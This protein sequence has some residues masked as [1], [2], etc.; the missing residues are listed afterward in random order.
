MAESVPSHLKSLNND[1]PTFVQFVN[2]SD[3]MVY[4]FWLDYT[5]KLVRYGCIPPHR[6]ME[7]NTYVTH[8]WV[9]RDTATWYPL[10]LNGEQIF[11]PQIER[12]E[13]LFHDQNRER[14]DIHIPVFPLF[15]RCLEVV[16][17]YFQKE[18]IAWTNIPKNIKEVLLKMSTPT[19]FNDYKHFDSVIYGRLHGNDGVNYDNNDDDEEDVEDDDVDSDEEDDEEENDDDSDDLEE[20][21]GNHNR[22]EEDN[23]ENDIMHIDEIDNKDDDADGNIVDR[24]GEGN[25][26]KVDSANDNTSDKEFNCDVNEIFHDARDADVDNVDSN[27]FE[28]SKN[29]RPN[30]LNND[31]SEGDGFFDAVDD[32]NKNKPK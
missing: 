16:Y 4:L 10:L 14:V 19:E 11:F 6:V 31:D 8:P 3:R 7:M 26:D 1:T 32:S 12:G 17:L 2:S 30:S 22:I 20:N 13:Q 15:R 9:A 29:V 24:D 18:T 5:G 23:N 27:N 28:A 21:N 25:E